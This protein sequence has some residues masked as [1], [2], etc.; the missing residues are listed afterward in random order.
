MEGNKVLVHESQFSQYWSSGL[1]TRILGKLYF[2]CWRM[3]SQHYGPFKS[4]SLFECAHFLKI[5][6]LSKVL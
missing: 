4:F 1:I 5:V 2:K 6:Y 3:E